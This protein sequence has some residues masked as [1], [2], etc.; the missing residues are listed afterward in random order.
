MLNELTFQM[1]WIYLI[2]AAIFEIGWPLGFKLSDEQPERFW[3]W[4]SLATISMALS[5]IFLYFAQRVIPV[6]TAYIVWTGLG[7]IGTLLIGIFFFGD[8]ASF[9]RLFFAL[10]I[11]VGI[12]GLELTAQ[13]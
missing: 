8:S 6:S 13:K 2:I 7:A 9:L 4:I 11:L 12:V 10:L 3:L 1:H 5:G